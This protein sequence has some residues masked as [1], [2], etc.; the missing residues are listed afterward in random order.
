M[1]DGDDER[2]GAAAIGER[3]GSRCTLEVQVGQQLERRDMILAHRRARYVNT[4]VL[5]YPSMKLVVIA[6][7][8]VAQLP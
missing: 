4:D 2:L 7:S 1:Q 6:R 8:L 3:K 5:L